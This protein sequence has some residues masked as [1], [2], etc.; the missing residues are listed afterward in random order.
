MAREPR[1]PD[2][3]WYCDRCGAYLNSQKNFDDHKYIWK[4]RKCGYKNSISL[5]NINP[6]DSAVTE[7]F[8]YFLGFLS[9]ISFWTMII[10][11]VAI[12]GFHAEWDKYRIPFFASI[13]IYLL[14]F[15][16]SILIEFL[17]RHTPFSIKNLITVIFRNLMEDLAAPFLYVKEL[18]SN[19]LSFFTHKLPF[20]RKYEWHSN[21][22]IIVFSIVYTLIAVL[23]IVFLSKIIGYSLNDW[24]NLISQGIVWVK[25]IFTKS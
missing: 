22:T 25:Q 19:F 16:I 12:F 3:D 8:L 2:I 14:A 24:R 15:V 10:L 9:Y 17:V 23:E 1:F 7:Y 13:G 21:K 6:G 4:C 18:I 5:A 11:A 20:M